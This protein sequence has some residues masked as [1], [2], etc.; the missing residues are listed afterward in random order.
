PVETE[1]MS[2]QWFDIHKLPFDKMWSDDPDW[3]PHVLDGKKLTSCFIFDSTY[4]IT[5]Q[6][7]DFVTDFEKT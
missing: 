5:S 3:L 1:E 2:P 4:S 6:T 7:V